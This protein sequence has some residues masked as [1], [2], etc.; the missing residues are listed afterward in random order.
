LKILE[1]VFQQLVIRHVFFLSKPEI[2][3]KFN[4]LQ[5]EQYDAKR[6]KKT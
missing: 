3:S 2:R 1:P 5:D 4:E 6:K